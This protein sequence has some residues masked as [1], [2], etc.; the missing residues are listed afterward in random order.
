[1]TSRR[2]RCITPIL[3][4]LTVRLSRPVRAFPGS[5]CATPGIPARSTCPRKGNSYVMHA[6]ASSIVRSTCGPL[7][8]L[9]DAELA[10]LTGVNHSAVIEGNQRRSRHLAGTPFR[11][12]AWRPGPDPASGGGQFWLVSAGTAH[13]PG[14]ALLPVNS[15]VFVGPDDAGDADVRGSDRHRS[16]LHAVPEARTRLKRRAWTRTPRTGRLAKAPRGCAVSDWQGAPISTI[17]CS[18]RGA[19]GVRAL[20]ACSCGHSHDRRGGSAW[21]HKA[22]WRS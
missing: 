18:R 13:V 4:P 6:R 15:C 12:A 3:I 11:R 5:P 10:A 1:M 14:G 22:F 17:W 7:A 2:C 16:A 8:P 19:R 21:R 9:T 20:A